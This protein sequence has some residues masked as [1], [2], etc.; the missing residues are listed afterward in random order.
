MKPWT[1]NL[2]RL[3]EQTAEIAANRP[4]RT[5]MEIVGK[6]RLVIEHHFG[7]LSYGTE[8]ILV[9]TT[10]GQLRICGKRLNLCCMSREQLCVT[11]QVDTVELV[12][13]SDD[14]SLE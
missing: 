12:G 13:G 5:L 1:R 10:Y 11:G 7:I 4:G 8:Q 6:E 3:R 14:G 2:Q 9:G